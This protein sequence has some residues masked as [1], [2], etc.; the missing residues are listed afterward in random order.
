MRMHGPP[1]A[2]FAASMNL[3]WLLL[4][5]AAS[6]VMPVNKVTTRTHD[7][8]VV[9][10]LLYDI[11]SMVYNLNPRPNPNYLVN[12]ESL[13]LQYSGSDQCIHE[14]AVRYYLSKL[15]LKTKEFPASECRVNMN[16]QFQLAVCPQPNFHLLL[17][18]KPLLLEAEL[19]WKLQLYVEQ[20]DNEVVKGLRF[21]DCENLNYD[22]SCAA[23]YY[24]LVQV[25]YEE[26]VLD[27]TLEV[28]AL[29]PEKCSFELVNSKYATEFTYTKSVLIPVNGTFVCKHG[30]TPT[31]RMSTAVSKNARYKL[32]E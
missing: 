6:P 31:C 1:C 17:R 26:L 28:K 3:F 7:R 14:T 2:V 18:G 10:A 20:L 21:R 23:N 27:A 22:L 13:A 4:T 19:N 5:A 16:E 25:M 29:V 11:Y 9:S 30:R 15:E 12:F 24:E 8:S 32:Y